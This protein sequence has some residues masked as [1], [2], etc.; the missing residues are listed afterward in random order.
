MSY[1]GNPLQDAFTT[2]EKQTITGD[3][4]ASYTLD[5]SVANEQEIEV[6]VNNVRQEPGVAYTVSGQSLTMTGNVES[7]D[8]FYVVYQGKALQ[9][10]N[11]PAGAPLAATTGTFSGAITSEGNSVLTNSG[12][13]TADGTNLVLKADGT[14]EDAR[15]DS[16]GNF[17][18][19]TITEA[20]DDV[21]HALLADGAAYHTADN[22]YVGLFNRKTSD[23]LIVQ[24]R[25]DNSIVGSIG[26]ST[27]DL[28]INKYNG[29]G[30]FFGGSRV[31]PCQDTNGTGS[32]VDNALDIGHPSYRWRE[33]YGANSNI[34]TSD[35]SEKQDIE[36]LTEAE[37]RVAVACKG[38]LRKF[39]W[40]DAVEE[41]GDDARIHFGIIA[42]DLQSA[43]EAEGLDA[44]RYAMFCSDTWWEAEENYTD[45]EGIEQTRIKIYETADEAPE[46]A[47]ERTR[48]GVRYPELLAFIIGAL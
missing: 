5:Y 47:T 27:L 1:I 8:D 26:N 38:L 17:F 43:F 36:E 46:S 32:R 7:D 2:I 24:F 42:Q 18:V 40:I 31:S 22:R 19:K 14:N 21:G 23:G 39:R 41:K 48:L 3:G 37:Q 29:S 11:H 12:Y 25:K 35:G 10:V 9:T 34:S 6:F 33:I 28:I 30:L 4:G 13:I 44:D 15:I 45:D 16:S 20:S